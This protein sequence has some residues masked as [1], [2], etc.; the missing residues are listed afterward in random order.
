MYLT[1]WDRPHLAQ[2]NSNSPRPIRSQD[3]LIS[4]FYLV[5]LVSCVYFVLF[6]SFGSGVPSVSACFYND[7]KGFMVCD[8]LD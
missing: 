4:I 6:G 2:I 1:F 5:S 3:S 7:L 8:S